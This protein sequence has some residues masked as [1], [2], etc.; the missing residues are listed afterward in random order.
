ML[1]DLLAREGREMSLTEMAKTLDWPKTTVHGIISTLRDYHYVDQ[2]PISGHY[3]LGVRLFE[4]GNVVAR[5][6]DVRTL[7]KPVMQRLGNRLGELVQLATTDKGEVLY[8]ET[9]D[10]TNMIR[11]ASEIGS[12]LPMHCTGLGKVLLAYMRPSEAKWILAQH[13][14]RAR[15]QYTITNVEDLEREL[16]LIRSQGYAID[17]REF[18]DNLRCIAAPIY[19]CDGK[20]EY[21][22]SVSGLDSNFQGKRFDTILTEVLHAADDISFSMGFRTM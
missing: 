8:L 17:D 9:I 5:S 13:K 16:E 15:T 12:R 21:A 11:I 22:I 1:I 4:I 10:T 20:V 14:M 18:M 3:R 7:A 19:N 6:W 2:S